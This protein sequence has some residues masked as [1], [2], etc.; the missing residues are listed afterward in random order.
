MPIEITPVTLMGL[1]ALVT[2]V[3]ATVFHTVD[4]LA[5]LAMA[6]IIKP[7]APVLFGGATATFNMKTATSPMAAIE[8]HQ[9]NMAYVAV[10]KFL[11]LPTQAYMALSDGKS[12]DTQAALIQRATEEVEKRLL[13]YEPVETDPYIVK[14]LRQL[15][16]TEL[17]EQTV[18]PEGPFFGLSG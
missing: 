5:E 18:L 10:A 9:L 7:G 4:V 6:Q 2:L 16:Q 3:D 17:R 11:G 12:V 8:A 15:I 14:E 1:V 13:A